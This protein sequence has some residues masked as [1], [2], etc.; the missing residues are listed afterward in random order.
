MWNNQE[1]APLSSDDY[2]FKLGRLRSLYAAQLEVVSK[3]HS[4]GAATKQDV[5]LCRSNITNL[6]SYHQ[7]R[8]LYNQDQR[9]QKLYRD[10][11]DRLELYSAD[12]PAESTEQLFTLNRMSSLQAVR[13][14]R[15]QALKAPIEALTECNVRINRIEQQK[16][17][18]AAQQ[19]QLA[20]RQ[21]TPQ[22]ASVPL[23][24]AA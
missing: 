6:E 15:L 3:L 4:L 1:K 16:K 2:F 22:E 8:S 9:N 10:M 20:I 21:V 19:H 23:A 17:A 24:E 13:L 18:L 5:A 12:D 14:E 11:E 7:N